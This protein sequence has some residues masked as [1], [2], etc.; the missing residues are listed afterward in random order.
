MHVIPTM[1]K[2]LEQRK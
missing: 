2:K 1:P